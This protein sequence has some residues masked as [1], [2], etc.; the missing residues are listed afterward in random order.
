MNQL[1]TQKKEEAKQI[2]KKEEKAKTEQKKKEYY[3]EIIKANRECIRVN[4]FLSQNDGNERKFEIENLNT[5][6]VVEIEIEN[7]VQIKREQTEQRHREILTAKI[8]EIFEKIRL[9]E[10]DKYFIKNKY[11]EALAKF[12]E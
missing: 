4:P 3:E 12:E 2:S 11:Q 5:D 1:K 6:K 8:P 9:S 10:K 7:E